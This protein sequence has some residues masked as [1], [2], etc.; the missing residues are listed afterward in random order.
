MENATEQLKE[1]AKYVTVDCDHHGVAYAI[2]CMLDGN[3]EF[4]RKHNNCLH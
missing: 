1:V 4:I 2:N 3:L